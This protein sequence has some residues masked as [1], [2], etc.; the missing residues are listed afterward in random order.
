MDKGHIVGMVL[1]DLQEAF[2]TVDRS[3]FLMKL[4][5]L[6]LVNLPCAGILHICW[7]DS[8]LSIFQGHIHQ[9]LL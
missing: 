3:I 5:R 6:V 1:L 4:V 2:D 9:L 8:S 7:T